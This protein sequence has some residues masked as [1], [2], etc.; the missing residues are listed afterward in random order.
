M[1]WSDRTHH[2]CRN[3][4]QLIKQWTAWCNQMKIMSFL[5]VWTYFDPL[6]LRYPFWVGLPE[7]PLVKA[8]VRAANHSKK[9]SW[10]A[11]RDHRCSENAT[12]CV[13]LA[14]K[15]AA[16]HACGGSAVTELQR[17]P[18]P[19]PL[20]TGKLCFICSPQNVVAVRPKQRAAWAASWSPGPA[21]S[22]TAAGRWFQ[23]RRR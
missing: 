9:Y 11:N 14:Q 20:S 12:F 5:E 18:P 21:S 4:P 13:A 1:L 17:L 19:A 3:D 7:W 6:Q 15:V 23:R 16:W 2:I 8:L 22:S 10:P